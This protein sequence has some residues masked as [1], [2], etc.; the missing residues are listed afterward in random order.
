MPTVRTVAAPDLRIVRRRRGALTAAIPTPS[1]LVAASAPV[2]SVKDIF[3]PSM[4]QQA[5]W[6]DE[7]WELYNEVGE[8][9]CYV[10]WRARSCSRVKL[11]PSEIDPR[12]GQPTMSLTK[13][14]DGNLV[15]CPVRG[16]ISDGISF[17]R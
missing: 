6:Q 16:S 17:T 14:K 4:G 10:R 15:G 13:D 11:I 3:K 9:G 1:A 12:T 8:L 7:A 2:N 5:S